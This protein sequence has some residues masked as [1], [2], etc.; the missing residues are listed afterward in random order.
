MTRYS[1]LFSKIL[2]VSFL[3]S[4]YSIIPIITIFNATISILCY[5]MFKRIKQ[6][7]SSKLKKKVFEIFII[8]NAFEGIG[9]KNHILPNNLCACYKDNFVVTKTTSP[10]L[11]RRTN[12]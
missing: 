5:T 6:K 9:F 4:C 10:N 3:V 11:E 12:T 8:L 1:I 7:L 2:K